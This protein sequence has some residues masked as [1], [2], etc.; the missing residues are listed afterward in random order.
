MSYV[1]PHLRNSSATTTTTTTTSVT[2]DNVNDH[3][4]K[5]SNSASSNFHSKIS[6]ATSTWNSL[7]TLSNASRR[8][9]AAPRT[10]AVP[11]VFF[12]QWNPSERVLRLNSQQV[13]A[14]LLSQLLWYFV[15]IFN[16]INI[17]FLLVIE[18]K[19]RCLVAERSNRLEFYLF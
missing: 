9:S 6:S 7:P 12:P 18:P 15:D 10:V 2:L 8:T 13:S 3:I 19:W 16:A 14:P 17:I 1:P 11:E 4:T 5:L